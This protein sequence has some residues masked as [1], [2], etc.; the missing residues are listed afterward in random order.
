MAEDPGAGTLAA[1]LE[2]FRRSVGMVFDTGKTIVSTAADYYRTRLYIGMRKRNDQSRNAG[3]GKDAYLHHGKQTLR[4]LRMHE[5]HGTQIQSVEI[6]GSEAK[7]ALDTE[8]KR[9]KVDY[10][11]TKNSHGDWFL[12]YKDGN[13]QDIL[14]AQDSA[15]RVLYGTPEQEVAAAKQQ[16]DPSHPETE[17][18]PIPIQAERPSAEYIQPEGAQHEHGRADQAASI[19]QAKAERVT[20]HAPK[21]QSATAISPVEALRSKQQR[22]QRAQ[23]T[24][25]RAGIAEPSQ[26]QAYS[27]ERKQAQTKRPPHSI[28]TSPERRPLNDLKK[29][30]KERA[31]EKNRL[32]DKSR[33]RVHTRNRA[34]SYELGH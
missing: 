18:I 28:H 15:L 22:E 11:F 33:N 16:M 14:L 13:E 3:K 21:A 9:L 27:Q 12:H 30:A 24:G 32:R 34:R 23:E 20:S 4:Q 1:L 26:T 5:E 25:E 29:E 19:E 31:S 6:G 8:L 7:Q 17:H 2:F 10:A